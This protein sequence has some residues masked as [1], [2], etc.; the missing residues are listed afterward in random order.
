MNELFFLLI[1]T[2]TRD[3]SILFFIIHYHFFSFLLIGFRTD[4]FMASDT[5][6]KSGRANLTMLTDIFPS[7]NDISR[8]IFYFDNVV[9]T[10][11][12]VN[13]YIYP[14]YILDSD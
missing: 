13:I 1:L 5:K 6:K 14:S 2:I 10:M 3:D 7:S 11:D 8:Q 12:T 9:S 4:A